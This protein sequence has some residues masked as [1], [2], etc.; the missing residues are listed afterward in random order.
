M[1]VIIKQRQEEQEGILI[2][3]N[4]P[5]VMKGSVTKD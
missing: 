1:N 2:E 5:D 4:M 3:K